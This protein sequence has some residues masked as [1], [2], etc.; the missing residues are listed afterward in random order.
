MSVS[1]EALKAS[2]TPPEDAPPVVLALWHS[3]HGDWDAAH[4]L[5]Q[6]DKSVEAAWVHAHLHRVE[7]DIRNAAHWYN[8]AGK[9][10]NKAS[11]DAE[12]GSLVQA[13]AWS[14]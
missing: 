12:W 5:V 6:D 14:E 7:G 1:P 11:L 9:P 3:A 2:D 8:R 13:V 10:V 4:V